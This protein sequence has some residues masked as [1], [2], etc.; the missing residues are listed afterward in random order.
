L[1]CGRRDQRLIGVLLI[2]A[3]VAGILGCLFAPLQTV[4]IW[5]LVQGFG[6]GGLIVVAMTLIILRSPDA[7][8]AA[9]RSGM[10]Q[11]WRLCAGGLWTPSRR[12]GLIVQICASA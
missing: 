12:H 1:P 10:A 9:Q 4:W 11:G 3:A 6:Q 8:V 2:A 5:A 7:H